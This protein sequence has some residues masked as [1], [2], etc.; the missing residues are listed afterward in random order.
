MVLRDKAKVTREDENLDKLEDSGFSGDKP[1]QKR[2][3][4]SHGFESGLLCDIGKRVEC[5]N[6]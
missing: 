3:S 6:L 2:G 5:A 1:D 4:D